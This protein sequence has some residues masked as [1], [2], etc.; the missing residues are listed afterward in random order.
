MINFALYT[1]DESGNNQTL[2]GYF[3]W[4]PTITVPKQ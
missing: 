3:Q 2:Y 1:L 4:A